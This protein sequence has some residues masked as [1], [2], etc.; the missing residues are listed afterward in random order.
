M[1]ISES[2]KEME[3][4]FLTPVVRAGPTSRVM[5]RKSELHDN[6]KETQRQHCSW[7][8]QRFV[9]LCLIYIS[10][11]DPFHMFLPGPYPSKNMN[12]RI[13]QKI[14]IYLDF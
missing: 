9:K 11:L 2:E 7:F 4:S 13:L 10:V 12:F 8:L 5:R 1:R 6:A 3:D 14:D